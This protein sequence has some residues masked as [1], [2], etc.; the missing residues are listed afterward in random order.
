MS[1]RRLLK[2]QKYSLKANRKSVAITQHPQRDQQF[3]YIRRVKQL[4]INAGHPIISVDTKKKE[5]IG[6]LKTLRE[7]QPPLK[8]SQLQKCWKDL[9]S[10]T[11]S[12]Q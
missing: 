8:F 6:F 9:E 11:S 10:K 3:R 4:F 1:I 2:Q 7:A 5:L 12:G